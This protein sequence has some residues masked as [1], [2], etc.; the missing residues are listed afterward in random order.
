LSGAELEF[1]QAADDVVD[2]EGAEVADVRRGVDRRA[3][4]VE[5]EYRGH[6]DCGMSS[7]ARDLAGVPAAGEVRLDRVKRLGSGAFLDRCCDSGGT[8]EIFFLLA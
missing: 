8:A 1:E 7:E 5:A 4:V 3:A 6:G 2:D